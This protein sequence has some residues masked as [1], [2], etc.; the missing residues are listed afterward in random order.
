MNNAPA[1]LLLLHAATTA[2][3]IGYQNNEHEKRDVF[4]VDTAVYQPD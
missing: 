2:G 1:L 4:I 3:G